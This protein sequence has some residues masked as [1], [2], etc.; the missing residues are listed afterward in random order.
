MWLLCGS[1]PRE[2]N[3]TESLDRRRNSLISRRNGGL[4]T[5]RTDLQTTA[6]ESAA[7][8][9]SAIP[10]RTGSVHEAFLL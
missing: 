2:A 10:A 5:G 1:W 8:T 6:F 4:T 9:S 7:S 3:S